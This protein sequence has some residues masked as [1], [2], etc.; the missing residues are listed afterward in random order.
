MGCY[1]SK[2]RPN[3]DAESVDLKDS[4]A[5]PGLALSSGIVDVQGC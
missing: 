2:A 4:Q 5:R 3:L 1:L